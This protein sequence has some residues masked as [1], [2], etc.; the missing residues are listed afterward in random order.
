MDVINKK[1]EKNI[2]KCHS[3]Y[4][5]NNKEDNSNA[6]KKKKSSKLSKSY[7]SLSMY[8]ISN[9]HNYDLLKNLNYNTI[10]YNNN[11][12]NDIK[13]KNKTYNA[14]SSSKSASK[15]NNKKKKIINSQLFFLN[16]VRAQKDNKIKSLK[17][18]F[19]YRYKN[20]K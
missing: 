8:N 11:S 19:N 3:S 14:I 9:S 13:L 5:F 2:E 17:N 7:R 16:N 20:K 6:Q 15:S 1:N 12:K 10:N 4:G 18:S